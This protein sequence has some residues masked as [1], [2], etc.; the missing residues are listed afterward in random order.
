MKEIMIFIPTIYYKDTY[1]KTIEKDGYELIEREYSKRPKKGFK[2]MGGFHVGKYP[3]YRE[4]IHNLEE[5]KKTIFVKESR[6]LV[7][8]SQSENDK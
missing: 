7:K 4:A 5:E 3:S 8:R 2:K 1:V 6:K